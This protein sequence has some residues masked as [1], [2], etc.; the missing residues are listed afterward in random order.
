M[1]NKKDILLKTEQGIIK[2]QVDPDFFTCKCEPVHNVDVHISIPA[3]GENL[4]KIFKAERLLAEA[5]ISFDT[6]YGS[7]CRDWEF[8]WS[9]KGA[10]VKLRRELTEN[11]QKARKLY[12]ILRPAG[13][14]KEL[15]CKVFTDR[16]GSLYVTIFG[17]KSNLESILSKRL[18]EVGGTKQYAT[19]EREEGEPE[20]EQGPFYGWK[21]ND[22][23]IK[24]AYTENE[25]GY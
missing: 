13:D 11:Q 12:R 5:G 16:Y 7:G 24:V 3:K 20:P 17:K 19:P 9:L 21:W 6:G 2:E 14:H 4:S 22:E 15:P 18:E 23:V 10:H 8:D 1:E 25:S